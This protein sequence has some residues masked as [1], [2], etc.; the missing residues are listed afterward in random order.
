MKQYIII[1]T[2]IGIIGA[3]VGYSIYHK[4]HENITTAKADH[5]ISAI[6]L[7]SAYQKNEE[8][9]NA[10]YL[11]KIIVV[12]GQVKETKE[13]DGMV[14]VMLE[15]EDMLFGVRCQ[16]DNLSKHKRAQFAVGEKVS[17]K[18]KC[19]GSLMDVVMVRCVE[20]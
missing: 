1:F 4:P 18:G 8:N 6:D 7:F 13:E 20:I 5:T 12:E 2:L 19:T 15:S 9:A 17:L 14:N 10:I 3:G 11:D 16:L